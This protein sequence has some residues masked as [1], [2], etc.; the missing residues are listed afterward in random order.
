MT[1][2]TFVLTAGE[3]RVL[4]A[5]RDAHDSGMEWLGLTNV[6]IK[7]DVATLDAAEAL[8]AIPVQLGYVEQV[9]RRG[10]IY[11]LT[12]DGRGMAAP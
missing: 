10:A 11:R 5:M 12:A 6:A 2:T 3:R 8:L 1:R 4:A 7:A 9:G